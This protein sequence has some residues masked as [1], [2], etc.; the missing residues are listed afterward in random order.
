MRV[1]AKLKSQGRATHT[2]SVAGPTNS[3]MEAFMSSAPTR[4]AYT[5]ISC[6]PR[7]IFSALQ[8]VIN[9]DNKRRYL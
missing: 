3:R 9:K 8:D 2:A 6:D 5:N 1:D 4:E 7:M